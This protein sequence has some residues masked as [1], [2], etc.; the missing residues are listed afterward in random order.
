MAFKKKY[1]LE[2]K[3]IIMYSENIDL[4]YDLENIVDVVRIIKPGTKQYM[5]EK[6]YLLCWRRFCFGTDCSLHYGT[7]RCGIIGT[8][9]LSVRDDRL[10]SSYFLPEKWTKSL[11]HQGNLTLRR[12]SCIRA[13]E[14]SRALVLVDWIF[15][16]S[17]SRLCV[18]NCKHN[19]W[20]I[21]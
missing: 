11:Q 2:D 15:I 14:S 16:Y 8:K 12:Q 17:V 10:L 19:A 3:F 21:L 7:Y 18:N 9:D 20:N 4:Y 1:G 13:G 5:A 6:W